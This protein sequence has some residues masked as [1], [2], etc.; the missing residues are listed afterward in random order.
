VEEYQKS[1]QRLGTVLLSLLC[2]ACQATSPITASAVSTQSES[3]STT[4]HGD[5]ATEYTALTKRILLSGIELERMSL[6]YRKEAAKPHTLRLLRYM[7]TQET[8]AATTL[9]FEV[10]ADDQFNI[11]RKH[12]LRI[13]QRALKGAFTGVMVGSIVAGS[14]SCAELASNAW[15]SIKERRFNQDGASVTTRVVRKLHDLDELLA[16]REAFV[17]LHSDFVGY[18][19]A[20]A[21]GKL[22]RAMRDAFV[23]EFSIF[24]ADMSAFRT[25]QNTFFV[26]N[27]A[28][29]TIGATAAG[30]GIRA[31]KDPKLN[32]SVNI[33]FIAAG[34]IAGASPAVATAAG[35]LARKL[36]FASVDHRLGG[37][38][39]FDSSGFGEELQKMKDSDEHMGS[40]MPSMPATERTLLYNQ[41][42]D[43][44][45]AQLQNELDRMRGLRKVAL[46]SS[47]LGPVIG[48]LFMTQGI[49]G[50]VGYY[51]YGLR[52]RKQ[53]TLD[54]YG[55][56]NG[57]VSAGL[58]VV[59]N[60]AWLVSFMIYQ[61]H[62]KQQHRLP[63]QLI[64]D[65]L[66]HLDEVEQS[67]MAL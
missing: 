56:I 30:I 43:Y 39:P 26:L 7:A 53:L 9:A 21:E 8:G 45:K 54:L 5:F 29:N 50:T 52:P 18:P 62:L 16:Q 6:N 24:R 67:V 23:N 22:L 32:G 46:Q 3:V 33:M 40:L 13:N 41:S 61:N 44:F 59:G 60:A 10:V 58:N 66:K 34:G 49:L 14:G 12:P 51:R 15:Q 42:N 64:D 48:G 1:K 57:T 27:A 19:R 31:L 17:N 20:V 38:K 47:A 11:G 25:F 4:I 37:G 65:R 36:T 35:I 2:V 28:F 55:S 63:I